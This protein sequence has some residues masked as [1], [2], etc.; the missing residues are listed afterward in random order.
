[1]NQQ[2]C[3]FSRLFSKSLN[4]VTIEMTLSKYNTIRTISVRIGIKREHIMIKGNKIDLIPAAL[5]DRR[6]VYEWCFHS[7]TTKS[8]SGPPDYPDVAIPSWEEFCDDYQE[9]YFTGSKPEHGRGFLI[10]HNNEPVGFISYACFHLKEQTAELDI[11]M[12]CEA[13][14]GKGFGTDAII[15]LGRHLSETLGIRKLIIGPSVKNVR[16]I[17]SYEKAGFEKSNKPMDAYL[18]DEYVPIYGGGDYG[19]NETQVLVKLLQ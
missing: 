15:S 8:H 9:Y 13:N 1:M 3:C 14:C 6:D 11:W 2:P 16:A 12:N 10:S 17:K 5:G 18:R 19:T 4:S 7:E